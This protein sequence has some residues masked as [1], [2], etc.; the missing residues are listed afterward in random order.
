MTAID[1]SLRRNRR[2]RQHVRRCLFGDLHTTTANERS[3]DFLE[4][5][6]D[7]Y[8]GSAPALTPPAE[9]RQVSHTLPICRSYYSMRSSSRHGPIRSSSSSTSGTRGGPSPDIITFCEASPSTSK[10]ISAISWTKVR[11]RR[12]RAIIWLV[13]GSLPTRRPND[14]QTTPL[15]GSGSKIGCPSPSTI[16]LPPTRDIAPNLRYSGNLSIVQRLPRDGAELRH[17]RH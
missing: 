9:R 13:R 16:G 6:Q 14:L 1:V 3:S 11:S 4:V 2:S 7:R 5:V 10:G 12:G 17:S 15:R 8:R